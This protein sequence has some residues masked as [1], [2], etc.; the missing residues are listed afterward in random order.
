[1]TAR[2]KGIVQPSHRNQFASPKGGAVRRQGRRYPINITAALALENKLQPDLK[3][4]EGIDLARMTRLVSP[5]SW[6]V[7][8]TLG[9]SVEVTATNGVIKDARINDEADPDIPPRA[10]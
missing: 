8:T 4:G 2:L 3:K 1:M 7:W 9:R 10:R 6:I 5:T